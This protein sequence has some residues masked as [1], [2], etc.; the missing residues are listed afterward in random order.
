MP[1]P[2]ARFPRFPLAHLPTPL[3]EM[4]RL[5]A[6]LAARMDGTLPRL[7]IKRDDCTGLA[8]GGNKTRKLEFLIGDAL[9]KG[10]D[11]VVTTGALQSNHARQTAPAAAAAG[12]RCVLVLFDS[13]PYEGHAY[14]GSGNLLLDRILGA[15]VR[16]EPADAD[17]AAVFVRAMSEIEAGGG[18]P[19]LVPVG[20][21]N[22]VGSL[23]Y[24]TAYLEISDGLDALGIRTARIV[25]AS[26][27]GGTQAGLVAGRVL[28]GGGPAI[29]GVNVYR[30]DNDAMA[31]GILALAGKTTALLGIAAPG[32]DAVVLDGAHLGAR[33][34]MPTEE[35]QAAV[36]CLAREEGVL[37]DPVYTG[38]G[39]AGFIAQLLAGAHADVEA[40]VFL[41][42][43]G[44]PGLFAYEDEF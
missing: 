27:S 13:V 14:R 25:H 8:G 9:A 40:L 12:L 28:R 42:T 4:T 39:M 1:D 18:K 29:A 43:G 16:V 19:Y 15:D 31:A 24:A 30:A 32:P 3:A 36:E 10:C 7:F 38:K 22:A 11:T 5:R 23:G 44:M 41:H 33:Y 26:S 37:L 35:M 21:S 6:A 17:A 20:G 34:G 2:L